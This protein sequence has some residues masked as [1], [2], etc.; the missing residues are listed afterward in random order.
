[1]AGTTLIYIRVDHEKPGLAVNLLRSDCQFR[2][3]PIGRPDFFL[4]NVMYSPTLDYRAV[5]ISIHVGREKIFIRPFCYHSTDI[6]EIRLFSVAAIVDIK[7]IQTSVT[8]IIML[9][10]IYTLK[11]V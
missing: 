8:P 7:Q 3:I 11:G 10:W 6:I 5:A 1:L 9:I 4:V 2:R